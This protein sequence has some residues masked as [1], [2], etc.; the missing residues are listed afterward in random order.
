[1]FT[2]T[3]TKNFKRNCLIAALTFG[4]AIA[5]VGHQKSYPPTKI[6]DSLPYQLID[7]NKTPKNELE[8]TLAEFRD[9]EVFEINGPFAGHRYVMAYYGLGVYLDQPDMNTSF[10]QPI[11]K[12]HFYAQ[13]PVSFFASSRLRNDPDAGKKSKEVRTAILYLDQ[14]STIHLNDVLIRV[15]KSGKKFELKG[16][17]I[18]DDLGG[19]DY[20]AMPE[21]FP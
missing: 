6:K 20:Q 14:F 7:L 12:S 5:F 3:N 8:K 11:D 15:K 19:A 4:A 10:H 13:M 2:N 21:N 9:G 18:T 17:Y 1:M 16:I